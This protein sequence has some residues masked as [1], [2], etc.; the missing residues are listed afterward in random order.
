MRF[1]IPF[2]ALITETRSPVAEEATGSICSRGRS[3]LLP[4]LSLSLLF[5]IVIFLLLLLLLSHNPLPPPPTH[6]LFYLL[7]LSSH[8]LSLSSPLPHL[9]SLPHF[10]IIL[11]H[12]LLF[13]LLLH[14]LLVFLLPLVLFHI[15][16]L[17][18]HIHHLLVFLLHFVL[19]FFSFSSFLPA[20]PF[21]YPLTPPPPASPSTPPPSLSSSLYTFTS[22]PPPGPT[23]LC[24]LLFELLLF[25]VLFLHLPVFD[26][27]F[28][29]HFVL[30][31]HFFLLYLDHLLSTS[32]SV[33]FL[34]PASHCFSFYFV[35]RSFEMLS[36]KRSLILA[37]SEHDTWKTVKGF[38]RAVTH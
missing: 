21:L 15:L 34:L 6:S 29:P 19:I 28:L 20:F 32:F 11:F 17:L 23:P 38:C 2:K 18:F 14:V 22:V 27:H 10:L 1:Q 37:R 5:H 7:P 30:L 36:N 12:I 13:L 9:P 16:L 26:L 3:L 35:Q 4:L 31:S 33:S 25:H 8:I 24:H